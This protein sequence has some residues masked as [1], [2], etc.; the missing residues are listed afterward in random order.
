ML[1][2]RCARWVRQCLIGLCLITPLAGFAAYP[3]KPIRL[4]VPFP[5]GGATDISARLIA[6]AL[7]ARLK[8]TVI[9]DNR[10]GA[11][12][13]IGAQAVA[14]AP[15]DGYTLF[16]GTTGTLA[17]NQYLYT[18][19]RYDAAND[20][21]PITAVASFP[22]A[23]VVSPSLSAKTVPELIAL[24]K[25]KPGQLTYA[26]SGNGSSSH[27]AVVLFESLTGTSLTHVAYKGT[28]P[29]ITDLAGGRVDM[30]IGDI[31]AFAALAKEDKLRLLAVSGSTPS[32]LL[33]G[34]PTIQS[35]GVPGYDLTLWYNILAPTGLPAD[36]M[37]RLSDE[38]RAV[39][40]EPAVR[41]G[42]AGLAMDPMFQTPAEAS[43]FVKAEI[44]KWAEIVRRSGVK[45]E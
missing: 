2:S 3:E 26:S 31:G 32:P 38:L 18:K 45:P 1:F 22:N 33:P 21:V 14:E 15:A 37:K 9:V 16:Y 11:A 13:A 27:L 34:I 36:I 20:F 30:A 19:L 28:A 12:G 44:R 7:G 23:L 42:L 8:Q 39:K 10:A 24:A 17:I 40:A 5:P 25:S 41:Q 35:A 43:N 6:V 29:A 4:V